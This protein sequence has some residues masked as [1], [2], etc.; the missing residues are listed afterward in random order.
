MA[1]KT[2]TKGLMDNRSALDELADM[3]V[4][5]ETV[6]SEDLQELLIRREVQVAE[7]V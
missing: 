5:Q 6:D 7:Y 3:L 2:A 4:K 1:Y